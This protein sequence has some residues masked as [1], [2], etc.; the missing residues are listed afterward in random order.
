MATKFINDSVM[1][2]ALKVIASVAL[3]KAAMYVCKGDPA[4]FSAA[5]SS[6]ALATVALSSASDITTADSGT[7][8]KLV[9]A[10]M[11]SV[12]VAASGS[13]EAICIVDDTKLLLK[14]T[15]TKQAIAKGNKVTI[16]TF[17][18]KITAAT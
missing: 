15:C 16:P 8:R 12:S 13:A 6:S 14:T 3:S 17:T 2:G 10:Q 11:A 7:G 9:V 1:D 5:T 18:Y 4:T